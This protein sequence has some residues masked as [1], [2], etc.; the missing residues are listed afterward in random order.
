M[1]KKIVLF[2][3]AFSILCSNVYASENTTYTYTISVD[4][5]WIRTQDAYMPGSIYLKGKGL[6]NP[7]DLFIRNGLI[8]VAD[9]GGG[10][11]A[12]YNPED[13]SIRFVGEGELN[14]PTGIFVTDDGTMYIADYG[15]E[16]V[17]VLSPEGN[18]LMRIGRPDSHL[19]SQRSRYKPRNVVLT[20]GGNIFVVGEGAYEGLMQFNSKGEFLGYFAANKREKTLL[21][22][23]Q[24]IIFTEE[25]KERIFTRIPRA[26]QNIDISD[27]DLIYSVTQ[28]A[29][30]SFAWRAAEESTDNNVKM[31]NMAG[32]DILREE[33]T[34]V[35]E[36]NFVDIA[37][38]PY[39]N[40]YALT[41][42]GLIYEYDRSGNLIFSFGGRAVSSE[43]TGLFTVASAIDIDDNGFIYVLDKERALIQMFYPTEF[44]MRTHKAIHYLEKGNYRESG[45]IW[46]E[47]L[48]LNGMSRIA[49][50]GYGK[51]LFHQQKYDEACKHFKLANEKTG[52]SEA[53]WEIRNDW[54]NRNIGIILMLTIVMYVLWKALKYMDR[55]Y[56]FFEGIRSFCRNI[57]ASK[58]IVS[59]VLYLKNLIRHPIDSY[60]Y[61]RRGERGSLASATIIY[62][63]AF[64]VFVWD[65]LFRGFT[66]NH[67]RAEDTPIL[68]V[69]ALFFVPCALWVTGNYMVS[70]INEGEGS[71]RN[72][73]IGTA[74]AL[75]PYIIFVPF[76]LAATHVLTLNEAFIINFSWLFFVCWSGVIL[77]IGIMEIHNLIIRE[78]V[79]NIL[80]TLFF[81]IIAV[82]A[83]AMLYLIWGQVANF[84]NTVL[85]E[86]KY[87]VLY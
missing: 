25:Q 75:A 15:A 31:H 46:N 71:L 63:M 28:D 54:I 36:W 17:T 67:A 65:M 7:E 33:G 78:A 73:Y 38:G 16:C 66:F 2:L 37:A 19:F 1:V 59:D 43:R 21:E 83:F 14:S 51:T 4:G 61:L 22:I 57:R 64:L 70:S 58:S 5:E 48:S 74:Y 81:M 85:G 13:D 27:R 10:R 62:I 72:V 20:S 86:V 69:A 80:L 77:F 60:Y 41:F 55:E 87:R 9:T 32:I 76:I 11:I 82:V 49:H 3:F 29:G 30:I 24:D 84:V 12:I 50:L 34:M 40:C 68:L 8:Y 45:E 39:G 52:Y 35:D 42:T 6:K 23:V 79:K 47:L 53:F 44:S 18:V 56:G 26:I